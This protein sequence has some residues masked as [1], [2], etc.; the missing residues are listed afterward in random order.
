MV[1]NKCLINNCEN[2]VSSFQGLRSNRSI[3]WYDL[4]LFVIL[5]SYFIMQLLNIF[6]LWYFKEYG[7]SHYSGPNRNLVL[8]CL[9]IDKVC[10][11]KSPLRD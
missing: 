5:I 4:I 9:F 11:L 3:K 1:K 6:K 10:A 8:T 2:N 7:M